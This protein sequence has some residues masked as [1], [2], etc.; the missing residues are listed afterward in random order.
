[1][2]ELSF[3]EMVILQKLTVKAA[4]FT[5]SASE[6]IEALGGKAEVI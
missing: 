2:K 3:S 1:M 5:K 4:R 6:K